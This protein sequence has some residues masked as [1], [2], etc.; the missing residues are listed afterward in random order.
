MLLGT[1]KDNSLRHESFAGPGDNVGLFPRSCVGP[2]ASTTC[3]LLHLIVGNVMW[4]SSPSILKRNK[5]QVAFTESF[6]EL[7]STIVCTLK[8]A[9]AGS[10]QALLSLRPEQ[11]FSKHQ[12]DQEFVRHATPNLLKHSGVGRRAFCF[13]KPAGDS[14]AHADLGTTDFKNSERECSRLRLEISI[15]RL[16]NLPLCG[17]VGHENEDFFFFFSVLFSIANTSEQRSV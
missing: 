11:S 16:W 10:A 15:L 8:S 9:M 17:S 1:A 13:D 7:T 5:N 2:G 3:P 14:D 4:P 6:P 12:H